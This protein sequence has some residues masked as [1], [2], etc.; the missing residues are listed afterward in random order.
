MLRTNAVISRSV[1]RLI[2]LPISVSICFGKRVRCGD[3]P[4][5]ELVLRRDHAVLGF[6][7][8]RAPATVRDVVEDGPVE[9]CAVGAGT[10]KILGVLLAFPCACKRELYQHLSA[11]VPNSVNP[12]VLIDS[13]QCRS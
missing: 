12:L 3:P 2:F 5:A 6:S 10:A 13:A 7:S 11:L 8:L 1:S 9:S 4:T